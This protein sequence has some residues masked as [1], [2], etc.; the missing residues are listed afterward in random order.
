MGGSGDP[1]SFSVRAAAWALP[2]LVALYRPREWNEREGGRH[3]T[4]IDL[5]RGLIARLLHWFPDKKFVFL[6]DGGYASHDFA[7]FFHRHRRR[8]ALVARFHGDAALYDP[9]A[10]YAGRGRPRVKGRKRRSPSEVVR[11]VR[12][13]KIVVDWYGGTQRAVAICD[14][15]GHWYKSGQGLVPIRWV[16]VRDETG[17]RRDEYHAIALATRKP[18]QPSATQ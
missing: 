12:L 14:G 17:K 5:A 6:G 9:P 8:A 7:S 10:K 4:P 1:G 11:G 15:T 18:K 13:Q 3:K 16:F 2:V